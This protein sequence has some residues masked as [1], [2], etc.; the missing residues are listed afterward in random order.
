LAASFGRAY[1]QQMAYQRERMDIA[2]IPP[3]RLRLDGRSG[4]GR[5]LDAIDP[6]LRGARAEGKKIIQYHG[7]ADAAIPVEYSR[8]YY[9]AVQK[10]VGG[11]VTDFYRLFVMPGVGHCTGGPGADTISADGAT[12]PFDADHDVVAAL[13]AWVEAGRAPERL[14]ATRILSE[15][16]ESGGALMARPPAKVLFTRPLCVYPKVARWTGEG[17]STDAL[18]YVCATPTAL[19]PALP[20]PRTADPSSRARDKPR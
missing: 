19:H 15:Q 18:N 13:L 12:V 1:F 8:R 3:E 16:T 6:D 4:P 2:T 5:E 10:R 17:A 7:S 11:D 9:A 20:A 14:I